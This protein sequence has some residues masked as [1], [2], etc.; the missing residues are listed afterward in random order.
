MKKFNLKMIILFMVICLL[1][2]FVV[3][4]EASSDVVPRAAKIDNFG[5]EKIQMRNIG[6][7]RYINYYGKNKAAITINGTLFND[8]GRDLTVEVELTFFDKNKKPMD[9]I[10]TP[11]EVKAKNKGSYSVLIGEK[12]VSYKFDDIG[13]YSL[14]IISDADLDLISDSEKDLYIFENYKVKI[15]INKNNVHN[16]EESFDLNF[17]KHVDTFSF[18]IPYRLKYTLEDGSKISK[19]V[20]MSNI[21]VNDDVEL[22]TEDGNRNLYIGNSDKD[23]KRKSY[24]INYNWNAFEDTIDKRDE[25]V[26]YIVNNRENKIDGLSFLVEFPEKINDKDVYFMDEHGTKLEN[27]DYKVEDNVISGKFDFL[28][29]SSVSYAIKVV[30]KDKYF[31]NT[32][33]NVSAATIIAIMVSVFALAITVIV[34]FAQKK[35]NNSVVYNHL[36]FNEKI[37]SLELGY[38]YNG[39]VKEKDIAT[40]LIN[41]ANK[42]YIEV[43]KNKKGYKIL[44]VK[45]YDSDDRVEKVFMKELFQNEDVVTRKELIN[46]VDCMKNNIEFKLQKHKKKNRLFVRPIFNYKL[47][48]WFMVSAIFAFSTINI[49]LEYQISAIMVNIVVGLIGYIVLL[50]GI[51][52]ENVRIEKIIYTFVGLMFI[53]APIVLTKYE[54]FIVDK[55]KLI[56]YIIGIVS[57]LVIIT[58][59][60]MMSTRSF[61]GTKMFNKINA[62]KNYLID[63][64]ESMEELKKNKYCFYEVLPYTFVLG[65]SDKWYEKFKDLDIVKPKWYD[66][67]EF[68]LESFYKDIKDIYAD[69]FISLKNSGK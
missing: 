3:A 16:V 21:I 19:R 44:K 46:N 59:T 45:E 51:L 61:Y 63:F 25:F 18:S 35:R 23:S 5:L 62:Y 8:Y 24:L 30:L 27:V 53:V 22:R 10:T 42:G 49:F 33:K 64:D 66:V 69:I 54:A 32:E 28:I 40:L 67:D 7:T 2:S 34:W 38:L 47:F 39:V 26:F 55:L 31:E 43:E 1:P 14:K 15:K 12:D 48:F 4:L 17:R 6:F 52:Y 68:E 56:T 37:N 57:M 65:I 50:Y 9:I 58:I 60:R 29:N 11:V 20:V 36:Y 13:F 41:L